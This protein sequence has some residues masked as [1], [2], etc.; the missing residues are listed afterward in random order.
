M[1]VDSLERYASKSVTKMGFVSTPFPAKLFSITQPCTEDRG[2]ENS[3]YFKNF[4]NCFFYI[5][6]TPTC[7]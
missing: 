1:C 5:Q 4:Y 3:S 6:S 7:I 2:L